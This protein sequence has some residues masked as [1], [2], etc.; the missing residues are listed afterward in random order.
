MHTKEFLAHLNSGEY[1]RAGSDIHLFMQQAAQRALQ[2]TARLNNIY[3]TPEEIRT[4]MS[5]LTGRQIDEGFSLFPPFYSDYGRNIHISKNVF[6]NSG[7]R[8]QDQGGITIGDDALIG[9]CVTLVT[10]NH[11]FEFDKRCDLLP[12]PIV[13]GKNVWIGAN[14]TILPGVTVGDNAIIA[15]GAVVTKNVPAS[16]IAGGVPAKT[17]RVIRK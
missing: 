16:T 15:A 4:L 1:I 14:A 10:L 12:S 5:E 3:H 8:F 2:I 7:C 9:H 6:I 13:I 11:S 17:I